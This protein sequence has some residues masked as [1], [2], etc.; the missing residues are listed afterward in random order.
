M[1]RFSF[2]PIYT[3]ATAVSFG[4][5]QEEDPCVVEAEVVVL[6]PDTGAKDGGNTDTS[7]S[8]LGATDAPLLARI[9]TLER[10]V[11]G[12]TGTRPHR[13]PLDRLEGLEVEVLRAPQKGG[14]VERVCTT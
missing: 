12:Q 2:T 11:F 5:A 1:I 13:K 7:A 8:A 9:D 4:A 6:G 3:L 10:R 14:M